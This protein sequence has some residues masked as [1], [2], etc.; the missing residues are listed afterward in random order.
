MTQA[1]ISPGSARDP[2]P[3]G[4]P[5]TL[6]IIGG[7][8]AAFAAATRAADL[9][10]EVTMVNDGLPIGGTCVNVG[11]V[12]SKHLLEAVRRHH[13]ANNPPD[14]FVRSQST[15]DFKALMQRKDDLVETLRKANYSDVLDALGNVR[16]IEG[17]ARFTGS[18]EVEV[19]GERLTADGILIA[20][21]ARTFIPPV[22][23]L[24]EA[25]PL[26]NIT[27]LE[28]EEVPKS[29][30]VIGG[31]PLGLEFAQ[32]FARAGSDVSDV[33]LMG[34]ILPQH[35]PEV[36]EEMAKHLADEGITVKAGCRLVRVEGK[37]P[38]IK[39]Y[40]DDGCIATVE[41]V[42]SATGITPNTDNLGLETAGIETDKK[43][44]IQVD[45]RQETNVPGVYAAGDVTGSMP[46]ET[47]A[48]KQGYNAAHNAITGESRSIDYDQVPHAVF[49]DPQ[50]ASVG[51]TEEREMEEL[52]SCLCRTLSMEYVPK[53]HAAG[54]TRGLVKLVIHPETHKILGA[55]AVGV[56]AAEIIHVPLMAI[57]AGW[58]IDELIETVHVF[59]TYSEAWK[60]CAQ[61]FTRK[62]E[63][64][65]CCIV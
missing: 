43:G 14:G 9:G 65:S 22:P 32:I 17:R 6:L 29:I 40:D 26:T 23:G 38:E 36:S 52:G 31:G 58:T 18:R 37:T 56:N 27:A 60:M 1:R 11:C 54:D 28:L 51:W 12:P 50:V 24:A 44:F 20:T 19:D 53:A 2:A 47:V 3:L 59:P 57:R 7:G 39:L 55:H 49:T 46:L 10:V 34:R 35:E 30:A 41:R 21:G 33:E 63:A 16:L 62:V 48:A 8:A 61:S 5:S 45:A 13:E 4:K 42:L 64:M 25:E 15:L